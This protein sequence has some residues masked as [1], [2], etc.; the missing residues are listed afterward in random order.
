MSNK[1]IK[2]SAK[3]KSNIHK[4]HTVKFE[5]IKKT[6][7]LKNLMRTTILSIQTYKKMDI[8]TASDYNICIQSLE[9]IYDELNS[10]I[11][12][13]KNNESNIDYKN[14][15]LKL[16]DAVTELSTIF[17]TNGTNNIN[18]LI[19]IVFNDKYL[20][21]VVTDENQYLYNIIK[22]YFHPISYK[23]LNWNSSKK[24]VKKLISKNRIVEDFMIIESAKTFD[25]FD[26]A[27]TSQNYQLKISGIKIS[28]HNKE[29]KQTII[30]SGIVD[31]MLISCLNEPYINDRTNELLQEKPNE[32]SFMTKDY[33]CFIQT[34][35]LKDFLV[36]NNKELFQRYLGYINQTKL[37][38]QKTISQIVKEF[39]NAPLFSQ[40]KTLIQLLMKKEDPEFQYLAYLL[41]DL[42]SNDSSSQIDT[43]EQ[44]LLFDSLPWTIKK[45]FRDA[46]KNTMKYTKS[47][48]NFDENN[49]PIEQQICL[50][51][52][53]DNIKEKAMIKLKEVKS[54]SEDSG[55]KAR[56][57]LDGLLKI[58]FGIFKQEEIL[59]L[60]KTINETFLKMINTLEK[61]KKYEIDKK[62]VRKN[63]YT[64][65]E[66]KNFTNCLQN[67]NVSYLNKDSVDILIANLSKGKRKDLVKNI[68]TINQ[69]LKDN[70]IKKERICHSGKKSK[71]MKE[72]I[73]LLVQKFSNNQDIITPLVKLYKKDFSLYNNKN[74]LTQISDINNS[75]NKI[76]DN[77]NDIHD[78]L[79]TSIYGHKKAKRQI[80]R[81]IGQWITGKQTGYCFGFEG[82]PGV[83]KTSLARKGLAQ[84][85]KDKDG[86]IRPFSFIALGG[87]SNGS[88]LAGHNYT[89]VGSTWGKIVNI[90]M[91]SK[92]MN[93][94]I[95]ID[96]LDKVSRTE[97][98]KEI[99]GILT[100][101]IDGTQ[102][103]CF[104]DKY[105]NGIDLN[106]SK[107]LF[108]F[109]YN[110]VSLIDKVL[111]DRIH[112]VKFDNL[113][114][115]DKLII[116]KDYILPEIY[117]NMKLEQTV[118]I[119]DDVITYIIEQYTNESGVRKL[120]EILFEIISE[121]NLKILNNS[122]DNIELPITIS[123]KNI[124]EQYLK[125][126]HEI[127][128]KKIHNESS[129][130]IINGLWANALGMGGI[131][132][133]ESMFIPATNFLD[134]N[135]TG[136]QG[137]VMKES[138]TVAKTLAW[139]LTPDDRKTELLESFEKNKLQGIH[140]HCPEGAVPKDGPSAGTAITVTLF[141]LLNN[142]KIKHK[143]AITGEINLQGRVTAIGGLD[144]KILGGIRAG[145]KTF[146]FPEENDK[147][148]K[149]FWEKYKEKEYLKD[150]T[151]IK[152]DNIH[153]VLK[154]VFE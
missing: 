140:I 104:Q 101:L 43:T 25:C 116:T 153:E 29:T 58:P 11:I 152:V 99:I 19:S 15:E 129:I 20:P 35:I 4:F 75:W 112:R 62:F 46:M 133:I 38:K 127:N 47:L 24:N 23:L 87:S 85:L 83:G 91:D 135:L 80:E 138:M 28:L 119:S 12:S 52:A 49:I 95:F 53:S 8:I 61:S 36:Y 124:K 130:G 109:S 142:K 147:S 33:K 154:I 106:L 18:D 114:L 55:S 32:P 13:L 78:T 81:V 98:G 97:N 40:R 134:L 117:E 79:E 93:P 37:I 122:D 76:N 115:E 6:N 107:A 50:M 9:K 14:I 90:L 57:Y 143:L 59:I 74:L 125:E 136:L 3:K 120:K 121:I 151:F 45:Y 56:Q 16:K 10:I 1:K 54:K 137:D 88:T 7:K 141:S 110:D 44:T 27:R 139:K 34:L 41:Y 39:I 31:N 5:Y 72:Q 68:N 148:F 67:N 149:L 111:L 123:K 26:L 118:Y 146:V 66:I 84:C 126:R 69:L 2:G 150:I 21:S 103:E 60:M 86:V 64:I 51:K 113:N 30:V 70:N 128:H 102:N 42:L 132:P 73:A 22:L 94:I 65:M 108:V 92:C 48:S 131:I 63:H 71:Y 77:M 89:Y 82:P 96:E 17:K 145:V 100:H 105:F 144:L